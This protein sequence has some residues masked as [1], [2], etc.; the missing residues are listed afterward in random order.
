MNRDPLP[1]ADCQPLA[2]RLRR[3]SREQARVSRLAFDT[4][5]Q[6]GLAACAGQPWLGVASHLPI[7][8]AALLE[9]E[10]AE[11]RLQLEIDSAASPALQLALALPE[12]QLACEVAGLVLAPLLQ[13]LEGAVTGLRVLGRQLGAG[14]APSGTGRYEQATVVTPTTKVAVRDV[15]DKLARHLRGLWCTPR[16]GTLAAWAGLRL[17]P[18]LQLTERLLPCGVLDQL[19]QGDIVLTGSSGAPLTYRWI[20]GMGITMQ[21][22]AELDLKQQKFTVAQPPRLQSDAPPDGDGEVRSLDRLQD[23]QVPVA[24]EIDTARIS[25]AELASI[26]PGYVIELDAP[27]QQ[28]A[29]RLVC[30]GQTVGCGQLVAIGDQLGVRIT[31]MEVRHDAAAQR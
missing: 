18:R 3:V 30:H 16:A 24:F 19:D 4:R 25:L 28:A 9:I 11:G 15:D 22:E 7:A 29:V 23:L 1:A 14:R 21:A 17:R 5:I 26:R 12:D 2:R 20:T 13:G 8:D 6:Q 27:L 31:Q 10:T